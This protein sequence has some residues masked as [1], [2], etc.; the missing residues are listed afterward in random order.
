MFNLVKVNID[1]KLSLFSLIFMAISLVAIYLISL[2]EASFNLTS[3]QTLNQ[4]NIIVENF[5]V[6]TIGFFEIIG[7]VFVILLVELELFHNTD[8]FDS[9]FVSL[10]GK[11]QYFVAKII[12]YIVVVSMFILMAFLGFILIYLVRFK[13]T[14]LIPLLIQTI[15]FYFLYFQLMFILAYLFVLIFK[16]YFSAILVFIYYW[17]TKMIDTETELI[18][19]LFPKITIN[20]LKEEVLFQVNIIY[21]ICLVLF[22]FLISSK[23]YKLKDLKINS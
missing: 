4:E 21:I 10:K 6:E 11:K 23:I 8:N 12:S 22:L 19:I 16:N 3:F 7:V 5:F 14:T 2:F 13:T 9:Y 1:K 15:L 18:N 17:I 20:I